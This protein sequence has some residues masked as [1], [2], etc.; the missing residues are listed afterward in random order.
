MTLF[1]LGLLI[2]FGLHL[3]TGLARGLRAGMISKMGAGA[4]KWLFSL[5]SLIGFALI[6]VGWRGA[7]A[8]VLYATPLWLRHITYLLVLIAF[9]LLAASQL[10]AGKIAAAT[11]HPMLAAVKLW[12]FAHLLVNGEVRSVLLFGS[13]LAFGVI[14]RIAVKKRGDTGRAAG[15][16]M[17]DVIAVIVGVAAYAAV[18]LYGHEYIAGIALF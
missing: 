1:I 14:D 13:F 4:Y 11:K 10:P 8:S 3:C 7:D 5:G 2:F 6:I 18:A 9:I 12:A 17:N 15:P 16:V